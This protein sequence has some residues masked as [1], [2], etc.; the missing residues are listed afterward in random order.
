ME[1]IEALELVIGLALD[2]ILEERDCLD[3]EMLAGREKALQAVEIVEIM[4]DELKKGITN[5][6]A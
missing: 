3:D 5:E 2:E 4:L 6:H 1:D